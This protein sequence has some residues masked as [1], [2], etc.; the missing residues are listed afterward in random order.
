MGHSGYA[1]VSIVPTRS[2]YSYFLHT[3]VNPAYSKHLLIVVCMRGKH[4]RSHNN[5]LYWTFYGV[6]V[7]KDLYAMYWNTYV[8]FAM[9]AYMY[10]IVV[11]ARTTMSCRAY[12]VVRC[13]IL[14]YL[15]MTS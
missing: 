4:D 5:L 13:I 12:C 8:Y 11:R 14:T 15:C 7:Q 1:L 2:S 10:D 3:F 6:G 9:R